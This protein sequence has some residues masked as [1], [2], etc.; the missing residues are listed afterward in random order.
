M[1]KTIFF[2]VFILIF[3]SGIASAE[4]MTFERYKNLVTE[5]VM[6]DG[7]KLNKSRTMNMRSSFRVEFTGDESK[8]EMISIWLTLGKKMITE[9]EKMGKPELFKYKGR[10]GMYRDG[11]KAGIGAYILILKN[12]KGKLLIS[13]RVFGGK[14][15][16]KAGFEKIIENI[17]LD[18]LEN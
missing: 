10:E 12:E 7:F 11:N 14:F 15:L 8:M 9:V 18:K 4:E 3:F 17:G 16:D 6:P 2:A 1:K 13:H 5:D